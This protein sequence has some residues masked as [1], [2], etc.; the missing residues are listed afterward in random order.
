MAWQ[1]LEDWLVAGA[2]GPTGAKLGHG[3]V[4]V[5]MV[6]SRPESCTSEDN[7]S[8]AVKTGQKNGSLLLNQMQQLMYAPLM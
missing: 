3:S 1:M 7:S 8:S 6:L 4:L 2:L 5:F